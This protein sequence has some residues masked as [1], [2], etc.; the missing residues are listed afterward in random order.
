MFKT[1]CYYKCFCIIVSHI[2]L[3]LYK[4][5]M[6]YTYMYTVYM[7]FFIYTYTNILYMNNLL[8]LIK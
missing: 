4:M 2:S 7:N 6:Y 1:M 5:F 8:S 3:L